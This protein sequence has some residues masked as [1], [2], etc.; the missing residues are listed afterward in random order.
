MISNDS[1]LSSSKCV[2][3]Y[4]D[5]DFNLELNKSLQTKSGCS[6]QSS[7]DFVIKCCRFT[8]QLNSLAEDSNVQI[9]TDKL[10]LLGYLDDLMFNASKS[11]QMPV[12]AMHCEG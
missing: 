9:L 12:D 11:E 8:F 6:F 2:L 1:L 10:I 5:F 4:I 7:A 3:K